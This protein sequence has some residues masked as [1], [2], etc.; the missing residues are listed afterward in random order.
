VVQHGGDGR[1]QQLP[2]KQHQAPEAAT[3]SEVLVDGSVALSQLQAFTT[4]K[5]SVGSVQPVTPQRQGTVIP[6]SQKRA[7]NRTKP[8]GLRRTATKPELVL[9]F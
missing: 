5:D 3:R 8:H 4:V 6:Y 1:E 9:H 2:G 7:L